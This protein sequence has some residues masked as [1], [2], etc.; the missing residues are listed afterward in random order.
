MHKRWESYRHSHAVPATLT[1]RMDED[2]PSP[3]SVERPLMK[4]FMEVLNLEMSPGDGTTG[5]MVAVAL[6][7]Y[8]SSVKIASL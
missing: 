6:S 2:L 5:G 8:S 7:S 1:E 4:D 3:D